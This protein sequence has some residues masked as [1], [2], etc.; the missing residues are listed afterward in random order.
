MM[1]NRRACSAL[2]VPANDACTK[3]CSRNP[4]ARHCHRDTVFLYSLAHFHWLF[5]VLS[6][7]N[8]LRAV[9][10]ET[11]FGCEARSDDGR[12]RNP[13]ASL[14][15]SC[16]PAAPRSKSQELPIVH[17][18]LALDTA[19]AKEVRARQ[20]QGLVLCEQDPAKNHGRRSLTL[21]LCF[22]STKSC[23]PD[24]PPARHRRH[25]FGGRL[26]SV[27]IGITSAQYPPGRAVLVIG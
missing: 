23:D 7:A 15:R 9:A 26:G 20:E 27:R 19:R 12:I 1:L 4:S 13:K 14:T 18:F 3:S 2:F 8:S 5:R 6:L 22:V 17:S 24:R 10:G 11:L 25:A 21:A 16:L